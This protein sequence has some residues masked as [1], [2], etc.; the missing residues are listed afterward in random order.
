MA[1]RSREIGRRTRT[2]TFSYDTEMPKD[3]VDGVAPGSTTQV[4]LINAKA[5]WPIICPVARFPPIVAV[6]VP[7]A[8]GRLFVIARVC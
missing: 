8:A 7:S 4:N 5:L 1:R 6:S 3:T 2:R